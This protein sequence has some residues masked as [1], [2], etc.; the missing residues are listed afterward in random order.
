M[1]NAS[2]GI[3][4]DTR[5]RE[6]KMN[7]GCFKDLGHPKSFLKDLQLLKQVQSIQ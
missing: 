3:K 2:T 4:M 6:K 5:A 7:L 1:G